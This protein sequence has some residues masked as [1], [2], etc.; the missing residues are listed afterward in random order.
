MT[1]IRY[2]QAAL[3]FAFAGV[4]LGCHH[5]PIAP[6]ISFAGDSA[7]VQALLQK[8]D[9]DIL[10]M[11]V[12]GDDVVHMAQGSRA[13]TNKGELQ[14]VLA[15]EATHGRSNMK[16]EI[17]TLHSS[18]DFVL[19][20]GRARGTWR[21]A[22]GGTPIAFETNNMITF[23]RESDGSLK[24]WHVIFNRVDLQRYQ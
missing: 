5:S 9:D 19:T 6:T 7:K 1:L 16:H 21:P 13:I 3:A 15:L 14:K 11:S 2:F 8:I 23:R 22:T 10:D 18:A 12:Y 4:M 20:Q 24:I 17:V